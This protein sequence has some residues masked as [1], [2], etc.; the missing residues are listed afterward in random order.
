MRRFPSSALP[1]IALLLAA[2]A[3]AQTLPDGVRKVTAAEGITEYAF[4]NGLHVLLFP[5]DSKPK[6]TVNMTYLVG[7]RHEGYGETGMA[8]LLE[9]LMFRETNTRS[10]IKKEL[11]DHGAVMNGTTS[12]DRTN[13]FE[14]LNATDENLRWA[15]ELEADRM[16]NAHIDKK[17]LDSEMTV[18][19]NEFEAGENSPDRILF[20]RAMETAY[21]W[22]NYGKSP[23]GNRSDIENVPV[24]KLAAF[25]QRYY[26]PDNAVLT[27]AGKFSE[28]Q[29]L[30]WIAEAF[31]RI[32]KPARTLEPTY[33]TEPTQ[34]GERFVALRRVGDTQS[35]VALYHVPAGSHPDMAAMEVLAGILGD[36]PSGRLY[37]ALVENKKAVS[38]SAGTEDLHDP[39]FFMANARLRTDQSLDEA[40]DILLGTIEKLAAEPPSKEE[41]ER[42]KTRLL[43]QVELEMA[44]TQSVALELSD[45]ESQ[46]DW[47]L[48]FVMRDRIKDVTPEDVARVAKA[49]L[50][51]SNR[52]LAEFIP[53]AAP[54]RAE[55]PP[56]PNVAAMLKDFKGGAA[57]A[58]GEAFDPSPANIETRVTRS[59][60]P[61]GM[62]LVLLPKK[63]RGGT[64]VALINLRFGDEKSLF[65]K[66]A[67]AQFAG[68][69]LLRGTKNHTRQQIQDELDRLK[70]RLNVNGGATNATASIETVEAS[71]PDV[72]RLAAEVLR[73]PS[74]PEKEFEQLRQQRL[75]GIEAARS[76]PGALAGIAFQKRLTPFA[77]GDVRYISTAD[78]QIED[79]KNVSLD[80]IRKF[81]AQFYGASDGELVIVGQFDPV[82]ARKL[83]DELFGNWKSPSGYKRVV[84]Q[85]Q[86][87]EAGNLTIETPDKQNA[88]LLAG[89]QIRMSDE[90][91]DYPAME[92][93]NFI[94]G[95]SFGSRLVHRIR[96][97]EGLS[98]G[99]R[100]GFDA[101]T[102]E[103]SGDFTAQ[104]IA[105][106]QNVP[107]AEASLKDELAR[108]LKDGFTKEEIDAGKKAMLDEEL[109]GRTQDQ[110][111][112][113]LLAVRER[114]G[115][116]MKFDEAFEDKIGGL[117]AEQVNAALRRHLDPA[118]F[119]IVKAGDF[120]KAGVLQ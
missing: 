32:A 76:D 85:F 60:L 59:R 12:W 100:S 11:T 26:E 67:V 108:V 111:L 48:F 92:L 54:D 36:A 113:R 35:V 42:V 105:A 22:H 20:Q 1:V 16:V 106:P 70:A 51:P 86:K 87:T 102:Q 114:F 41:V 81:H 79:V 91:A 55:I 39:G 99:V 73:E 47:R 65:G 63:T 9:H 118:G 5:D 61:G 74:Y 75:A 56:A 116:T 38:A 96:E 37:K 34:D 66:N 80:D 21:A 64:V 40:R 7:S 29:T 24:G 78:E 15:I 71:L 83:A 6:V 97:Q 119:V 120:K 27:I 110:G 98:Y 117:S 17:N 28:G 46:G 31:G 3:W 58:P 30:A 4:P 62:K 72:M 14:T 18:V 107:K 89:M 95:G 33:T 10:D 53:T 112:A 84:S 115:R 25:Y 44:N 88:T 23:I 69:L 50:K 68:G 45:W 93:A 90:D 82:Q 43:K 103:D 101:P 77:R 13:Y 49:Y 94:L 52:T 2:M 109:V 57:I 19:R 8:H 104:L